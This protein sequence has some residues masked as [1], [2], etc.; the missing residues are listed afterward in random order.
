MTKIK[1]LSIV[2]EPTSE[3]TFIIKNSD[4][5]IVYL[6][7]IWNDSFDW[8][9][10]FYILTLDRKCRVS[11]YRCISMGTTCATLVCPKIVAKFAIESLCHGIILAHNHPSN[12]LYPSEEDKKLTK[13]VKEGLGLFDIVVLDHIIL[14]KDS[15]YSFVEEGLL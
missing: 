4:E 1:K 12:N 2:S 11:G 14:T 10:S 13:K 3:D 5:A 7:K 8:Q 6:K 9:E 15:Y